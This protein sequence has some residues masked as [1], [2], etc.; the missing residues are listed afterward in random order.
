MTDPTQIAAGDERAE[1]TDQE[2]VM[3]HLFGNPK[4][5]LLNISLTPGPNATP[6]RVFAAM[7]SA[8]EQVQNGTAVPSA[9]FNDVPDEPI[10]VR[11]WLASRETP[12]AT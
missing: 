1:M 6:Q 12:N 9:H 3:N 10:D 4:R 7:R 8:F 2:W 11:D 5:K